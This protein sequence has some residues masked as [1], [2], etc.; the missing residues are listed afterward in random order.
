MSR[1]YFIIIFLTISLTSCAQKGTTLEDI[2]YKIFNISQQTK[3]DNADKY[4]LIALDAYDHQDYETAS[5]Y[6]EKLYDIS[7]EKSYILEAIKSAVLLKD[8]DRIKEL[9]QKAQEKLNDDTAINRYLVAYYIDQ[10]E[11]QKADKIL[12]KL[13][14]D[15]PNDQDYELAALVAKAKSDTKKA[16][17]LYQKA[18]SIKHNPHTLLLYANLLLQ[19][20]KTDQAIR[21]LETHTRLYGCQR[22]ICTAL[23][24]IYTKNQDLNELGTI[25][26]KLYFKTK[27]P[28]YAN[29]LLELYGYQKDYNSAISFLKETKFDD[30]ILLDIYTEKKDYQKAYK[31]AQ[32]LYKKTNDPLFLAKSAVLEY[33]STSYK[34]PQMIKRVLEKFKQ[35]IYK[36]DE[37]IYYNYYAYLL[38]DHDIDIQKGLELVKK[39]LK[40]EPKSLFY[41]DTQAWGYYK[42]HQCKKAYDLLKPYEKDQSQ[43]EIVEHLEKIK[44]CIKEKT[45]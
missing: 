33:E 27:A 20:N 38:I 7:D 28:L 14:L 45:K 32:K 21:V 5:E 43:K 35:S 22:T 19:E 23:I 34:S 30:T 40:V 24:K 10:K 4:A 13:L 6:F 2:K 31:L 9:L 42:L 17:S 26:K 15:H 29:A 44:K 41:I 12:Q 11:I 37:P 39:A 25:Y 1:Y 3:A 36:L 18:Y 8:Y 16:A